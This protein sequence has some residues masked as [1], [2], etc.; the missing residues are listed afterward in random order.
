MTLEL[1]CQVCLLAILTDIRVKIFQVIDFLN[2][3]YNQII[4]YLSHKSKKK[5]RRKMGTTDFVSEIKRVENNLDFEKLAYVV[6]H[7]LQGFIVK[8][9]FELPDVF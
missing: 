2:V 3:P 6:Q 7:G 4:S 9:I 1:N 5:K 8:I